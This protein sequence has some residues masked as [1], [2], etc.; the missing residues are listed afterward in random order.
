MS[1]RP[2]DLVLVCV[3][4][5]TGVH[6]IAEQW[7]VTPHHVLSQLADQPV[8]KF[9]PVDAEDDQNILVLH[10]NML[11]P[12]Q[13]IADP[14]SKAEDEHFALMTANLL[15]NLY[16]IIKDLQVVVLFH[17]ETNFN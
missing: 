3:E 5:P 16:S 11:I 7:E 8:L 14:M 13:S 6:K 9:Q 4:A 12:V 15:M 2:D 1:I 10:R 17:E